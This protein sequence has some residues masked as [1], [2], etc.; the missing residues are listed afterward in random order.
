MPQHPDYSRTYFPP[1]PGAPG[2]ESQATYY[3][4]PLDRT[5]VEGSQSHSI[6]IY[7][8]TPSQHLSSPYINHQRVLPNPYQPHASAF[9]SSPLSSPALLSS[10]PYV[11]RQGSPA[12]RTRFACLSLH[13]SN[14]IHF[15]RFPPAL[16]TLLRTIVS[17]IWTRG[18]HTE[19]ISTSLLEIQLKGNPWGINKYDPD[20][21]SLTSIR[22]AFARDTEK[23]E[24]LAQRLICSLLRALHKDG[25]M[26]MQSTNISQVPWDADTLLF[27]HQIPTPMPHQWFSVVF[28]N[29]TFRFVDAPRTLCLRVLEGLSAQ[30]LEMKFKDNEKV[31]DCYEV[32]YT[33]TMRKGSA[34]FDPVVNTGAHKMRMMFMFLLECI[35]ENGWT[36][37][38]SVE[39]STRVD[40]HA[41]LDTW[42]CCRPTEWSE[43]NPVYHN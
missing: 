38:A 17:D 36:L 32:K 40:E 37:Y 9:Q 42:Y 10:T 25:W 8:D 2:T 28:L 19:K 14:C 22:S 41:M 6:P 35:E 16:Y 20:S 30:N 31:E 39:Q 15:S 4:P 12:F 24:I 26:L 18:I 29:K 7:A 27:R 5:P 21:H 23:D 11:G 43:G 13:S 1:P 33:G 34:Y 3:P